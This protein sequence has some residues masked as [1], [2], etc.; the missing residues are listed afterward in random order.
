MAGKVI[1]HT[2]ESELREQMEAFDGTLESYIYAGKWLKKN[3]DRILSEFYWLHE[4]I[5]RKK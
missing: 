3:G 4:V 1:L 2:I 5:K